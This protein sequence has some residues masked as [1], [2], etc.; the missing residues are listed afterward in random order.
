MTAAIGEGPESDDP[1]P[2]NSKKR[3]LAAATHKVLPDSDSDD[4]EGHVSG[5]GKGKAGGGHASEAEGPS[6]QR[7]SSTAGRL[8]ASKR[9]MRNK[10]VQPEDEGQESEAAMATA[11]VEGEAGQE[12]EEVLKDLQGSSDPATRLAEEGLDPL[13]LAGAARASRRVSTHSTRLDIQAKMQ[14]NQ[15]R[16]RQVCNALVPVSPALKP[17]AWA[18]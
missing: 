15:Q 6:R 8:A 7:L 9:G 16:L 12:G 5:H 17:V 11:A 2:V 3:R 1:A 10:A 14:Q 13:P 18:L 4:D